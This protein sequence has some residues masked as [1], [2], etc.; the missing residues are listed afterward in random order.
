MSSM[1]YS[2]PYLPSAK[3]EHFMKKLTRKFSRQQQILFECCLHFL[4]KANLNYVTDNFISLFRNKFLKSGDR[5]NGKIVNLFLNILRVVNPPGKTHRQ[6]VD[7]YLENL[8]T[9][10]EKTDIREVLEGPINPETSILIKCLN[11]KIYEETVLAFP[12]ETSV[13]SLEKKKFHFVS[14]AHQSEEKKRDLFRLQLMSIIF[15]EICFLTIM[16]DYN[17]YGAIATIHLPKAGDILLGNR[18]TLE[19]KANPSKTSSI[20]K[21]QCQYGIYSGPAPVSEGNPSEGFAMGLTILEKKQSRS[22]RGSV[23]YRYK[24]DYIYFSNEHLQNLNEDILQAIQ[25]SG[26]NIP[27]DV[28]ISFLD[29]LLGDMNNGPSIPILVESVMLPVV[30]PDFMGLDDSAGAKAYGMKVKKSNLSKK[31]KY[32]PG[33]KNRY[34]N[35]EKNKKKVTRRST[36]KSSSKKSKKK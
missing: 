21:S 2:S 6:V 8:L 4:G 24:Q 1:S 3:N 14:V 25:L 5:V 19:I 17:D 22:A 20:S 35:S 13:K 10:C 31:S 32:H 28:S 26:I 18:H 23:N 7:N 29:L 30:A 27:P 9:S 36:R 12:A 11:E 15:E 33:G 16:N 34:P